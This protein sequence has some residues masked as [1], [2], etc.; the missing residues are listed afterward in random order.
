MRELRKYDPIYAANF[1]GVCV[2]IY[3]DWERPLISS[4]DLAKMLGRRD[5]NEISSRV[6]EV[7]KEFGMRMVNGSYKISSLIDL[8]GALEVAY[9]SRGN[10]ENVSLTRNFIK[11]LVTL[12][13]IKNEK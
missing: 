3:G 13:T 5:S 12:C 9:R 7:N 2:Q 11:K 8:D 1:D 4:Y 10:R 6:G